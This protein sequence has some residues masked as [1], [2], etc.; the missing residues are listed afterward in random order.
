MA[1]SKVFRPAKLLGSAPVLPGVFHLDFEWPGPA[2]KAGQFFMIKPERSG[3]FLPRPVSA[4][5]FDAGM[6]RFLI[7][8]RGR[9]TGELA[10][11]RA[12]ECAALSGPL[13]NSWE[14]FLPPESGGGAVALVAGGVGI[15]PLSSLAASFP[16]LKFDYYLGVKNAFRDKAEEAAFLGDAALHHRRLL[17]AAEN[18]DAERRGL[19]TGFFDPSE[20][21]LVLACGPGAMLR[22]AA[23]LC[24]EAGVPCRVSLER[25]MACGVGACLGCTV[26]TAQGNRRCCADGPVFK[27][28][29]LDLEL[30]IDE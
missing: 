1:A 4:K 22:A 21:R 12:G 9:G 5:S 2:P 10:A 27:A 20:Y 24:R 25:R 30:I 23:A 16:G 18:G 17:V 11:M 13:G 15:A 8:V 26:A 6:L 29:E 14:E 19:V 28:E 7:A 3:T